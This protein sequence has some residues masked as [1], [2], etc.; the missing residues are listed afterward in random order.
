FGGCFLA[1][2]GAVRLLTLYRLVTFPTS[3]LHRDLPFFALALALP[4]LIPAWF[5]AIAIAWFCGFP[6]F[7]SLRMFLEIAARD[8]PGSSGIVRSLLNGGK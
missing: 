4:L 8:F 3:V 1:T 5:M 6:F 7:I 2:I